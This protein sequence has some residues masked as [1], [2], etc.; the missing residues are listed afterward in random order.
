VRPVAVGTG[1]PSF[2]LGQAPEAAAARQYSRRLQAL[3]PK[4]QVGPPRL[5]LPQCQPRLLRLPG[6]SLAAT[7]TLLAQEL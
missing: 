2:A 4:L 7:Q 3:L 1:C 5:H 6:I